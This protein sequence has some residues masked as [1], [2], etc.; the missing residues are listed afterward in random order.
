[1]E[2]L[3]VQN[4]KLVTSTGQ[5][6][7]LRGVNI[8]GWMNLENF[9]NGFPGSESHLRLLMKQ[10][11]GEG[12]AAFFFDRLLDHFFNEE[13]L[14]FLKKWGINVVRLPLNYRHFEHDR[15]PF[16]YLS[17]GFERLDRILDACERNGIYAILDLHAVQ[18]WQ[19][20]DWHCD[21]SSRHSLFWS[22]TQ[23]QTR[24]YA[25]WEEIAK[26]YRNRT[27]VAAYN[28]INEPLTNA[29]DGRFTRDDVYQ[30]DWHIMNTVYNNVIHSIRTVDTLHLIMLEGDYYSLRFEG[31]DCPKD[32]QLIYSSHNYIWVGTSHLS[33]YP[34]SRAG[35]FWDKE[36]INREFNS[37]DGFQVSQTNGIPLL[38]GEFGFNNHHADGKLYPQVQ[39]VADQMEV[40]NQHGVHWTF[41]TYKDIGSM[42]WV[43]LDPE[44]PYMQVISPALEAKKILSTDFGWLEGFKGEVEINI[45]K[46]SK[47]IGSYL[48]MVDAGVNK[49][50]F[51]QAAMSTYTADQL[52]HLFINQFKGLTE[53]HIDEIL[54]SFE[55]K[56]C[57][58]NDSL[59]DLISSKMKAPIISNSSN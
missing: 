43:Q 14:I 16:E 8:G 27:V 20:G 11:L 41:W 57:I 50:Y 52:Q 19:N 10:E 5:S 3:R 9:I 28:V 59:N 36:Q 32:S 12:K 56:Q 54:R 26:R 40:Y 13:D 2:F 49:R 39:A 48:P 30:P 25:L 35:V 7:A 17:T 38:V 31:L 34:I 22:H 23:F 47:L 37:T 53:T 51:A 6:I 21:N 18:G 58:K 42:G 33:E 44:S 29:P 1:M 4:G 24:F 45:D 15:S 46:L 55:I